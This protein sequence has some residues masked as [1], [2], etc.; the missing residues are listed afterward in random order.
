MSAV[1]LAAVLSLLLMFWKRGETWRQWN[2]KMILQ[3]SELVKRKG[4]TTNIFVVG[5]KLQREDWTSIACEDYEKR[6]T[7]IMDLKT[8]FCKSDEE[9]LKRIDNLS[10]G[11][12]F[13]L[14]EHGTM[15][16]SPT[17]TQILYKGYEE[18]GSTVH[19]IIGGFAGLPA[20]IKKRYPLISLSRMTWPHQLARLLL[21]EQIYRAT[22][23]RKGSAYHKE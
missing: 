22:E 23:I 13:A 6:L 15:Y 11:K 8:H 5:K 9:L 7:P 4:Y 12:I 20:D 17:F 16:D 2:R 3:R 21:I 14:D 18:G 19:F 1:T 10:K